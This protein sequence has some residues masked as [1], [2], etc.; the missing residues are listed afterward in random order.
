M[1]SDPNGPVGTL[2]Y[3]RQV[4]GVDACKIRFQQILENSQKNTAVRLLNDKSLRFPT[5]FVLK[6]QIDEENLAGKLNGKIKAALLICDKVLEEKKSLPGGG[7]SYNDQNVRSAFF[8]IFRT[9]ADSDGLNNDYDEIMDLCASVLTRRYH[10]KTILPALSRLIFHR[11]RKK[12]YL[13]DLIWAFFQS[14][15][16]NSMQYIA[17][18]LRSSNNRDRDLARLLLHL[19]DVGDNPNEKERQYRTFMNWLRENNPYLYFTGETLQSSNQPE[20]CGVDLGAKYLGKQISP[21]KH[22][23]LNPLTKREADTLSCFAQ[24]EQSDKAMLSDYSKK[25]QRQ[26]PAYWKRWISLPLEKQLQIVKENTGRRF[27]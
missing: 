3:L 14:H 12:G 17:P 16:P 24:A 8:W 20:I 25:M 22:Q 9:G 23:P 10:D 13:H 21:K 27:L 5:L 2:E 19:P 7:I 1:Y 11:N 15:D 6:P 4:R 26:N 18:Y